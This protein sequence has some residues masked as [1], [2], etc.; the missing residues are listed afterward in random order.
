MKETLR[1]LALSAAVLT[2]GA[3]FAE[4]PTVTVNFSQKITKEQI[5]G[6]GSKDVRQGTGA[7]GYVYALNKATGEVYAINGDGIK[8]LE[9]KFETSFTTEAGDKAVLNTAITTDDAGNIIV[10][11]GNGSWPNSPLCLGIMNHETG[12][13]S[14]TDKLE[15]PDGIEWVYPEVKDGVETGKMVH[16]RLDV[17]G[18]VVGNVFD[19]AVFY[20]PPGLNAKSMS[21]VGYVV[22]DGVPKPMEYPSTTLEC[23]G[24]NLN[25]AVPT[26]NFID[27]Q[28]DADPDYDALYV[29]Q[30]NSGANYFTVKDEKAV[31]AS[32]TVPEGCTA[33][34]APGFDVITREEGTYLLSI[35]RNATL[36]PGGGT[37]CVNF[38]I[39]DPKGEVIF[40]TA[41]VADEGA[42]T[43]LDGGG[44]Y[45]HPV[46]A[47][48][49]EVYF[50]GGPIESVY[51][52]MVTVDFGGD[53]PVYEAPEFYLRGAFNGWE[54]GAKAEMVGPDEDG[55]YIYTVKLDEF[56]AGEFKF[57]TADWKTSFGAGANADIVNGE[58]V[59][60]WE[61]SQ[62]NFNMPEDGEN[63][64]LTLIMNPDF[65]KASE[66][67][68]TWTKPAPKMATRAAFAYALKAEKKD[69]TTYTVSFKATEAGTASLVLTSG[70]TELVKELGAVVKG[71]NSFEVVF[72]D[73][74]AGKYD[75][76]VRVESTNDATAPELAVM[77]V[78]E[79]TA[80]FGRG[81][82]V[83]LNDANYDSFGYTLVAA[84]RGIG[85][86]VYDPAGELVHEG[87]YKATALNTANSSPLH[88][89]VR[90][91]Q[92]VFASWADANSGYYYVDPINPAET[93]ENILTGERN[94][95]G[96][97][98]YEGVQTAGGSPCVAF[99]G[100]GDEQTMWIFEEDLPLVANSKGKLVNNAVTVYPIGTAKQLTVAGEVLTWTRS[101][102]SNNAVCMTAT[103]YGMF[104][105]QNR[106]DGMDEG[107][108]AFVFM[109][110][111][112][113][114]LLNA[115]DMLPDGYKLASSN[116]G[117]AVSNDGTLLAIA[118]Y[119][120]IEFFSMEWAEKVFESY[121]NDGNLVSS[122]KH[123]VPSNL[124]FLYSVECAA[125]ANLTFGQAFFD[126]G[127]NLHYSAAATS[128]Y[129][130]GVHYA[131]VVL[132]GQN[133]ANTPAKAESKIEVTTAVESLEAAAAEA[134]AVYYN[135]NGVRVAPEN[136]TYGVY[137][138]V[139]GGKA[140]KVVVK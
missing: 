68:A 47:N 24:Q 20:L 87:L 66:F 27:E 126:A 60:A 130:T 132:P 30:W 94:G 85:I 61:N 91:G 40:Q 45:V 63:V 41:N 122:E 136:M 55:M 107:T 22:E 59:E 65:S 21:A 34:G 23:G 46:S 77:N 50:W 31:K 98:T 95:D 38:Q 14:Y 56:A 7:N 79:G 69:P 4:A 33:G 90:N 11:Y 100:E 70:E 75:W 127:N 19:K 53:E 128:N 3:M 48:K 37:R 43:F 81:G 5:A 134:D 121:D 15:V 137:V 139:Q 62:K 42:K 119:N 13:I 138:K 104:A 82:L 96:L 110:P 88:G 36:N 133:V 83:T 26:Y 116:G 71:D 113:D 118:T 93:P 131:V 73:S 9:S 1:N 120:T 84:S 72:E 25:V 124:E 109:S 78:W 18:R 99:L 8:T 92:A 54:A 123:I 103:P 52:T 2:A 29:Q 74:E 140:Q 12:E 64:V 97:F 89:G 16:M 125:A 135:V 28:M 102:L 49:Y 129:A 57:G 114:R 35:F 101:A 105:G 10:L 58:K 117:I 6:V 112:G 80:Q 86:D 44:L 67:F 39:E 17:I 76:A 115:V 51:A 106:A 108:P 111:K 32:V